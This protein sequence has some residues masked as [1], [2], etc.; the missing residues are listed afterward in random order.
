MLPIVAFSELSSQPTLQPFP[1][2]KELI[3]CDRLWQLCWVR[4]DL[5]SLVTGME[6]K[7]GYDTSW[8]KSRLER[9]LQ[10]V[11][12]VTCCHGQA[13]VK[14]SEGMKDHLVCSWVTSGYRGAVPGGG[15]LTCLDW[16]DIV[17]S[18]ALLSPSLP[19]KA[20]LLWLITKNSKQ[21]KS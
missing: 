20:G 10:S 9:R 5:G 15:A 3:S 13:D 18:P 2:Y 16:D 12:L 1:L 19:Y 6:A 14:T 8:T 7:H 21:L 11:C 4:W 17:F